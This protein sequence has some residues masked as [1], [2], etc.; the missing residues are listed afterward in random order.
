MAKQPLFTKVYLEGDKILH[1]DPKVIPDAYHLGECDKHG[2]IID[3][4]YEFY[5]IEVIDGRKQR[6]A[7]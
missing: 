2:N 1:T 7:H 4:E 6:Q 3:T 5:E